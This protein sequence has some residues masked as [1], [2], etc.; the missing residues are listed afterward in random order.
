MKFLAEIV[1]FSARFTGEVFVA[2][3]E[4]DVVRVVYKRSGGSTVRASQEANHMET[5]VRRRLRIPVS[6]PAPIRVR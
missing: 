4:Q 1:D 6:K 5:Y 2:Y 3:Q